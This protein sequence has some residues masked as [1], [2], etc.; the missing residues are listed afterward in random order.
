MSAGRPNSWYHECAGTLGQ[1][2]YIRMPFTQTAELARVS[3]QQLTGASQAATLTIYSR[4]ISGD[5]ATALLWQVDDA[6]GF[7]G[8]TG[9]LTEFSNLV[10]FQN[11]TPD[12]SRANPDP[13]IYLLIDVPGG[14]GAATWGVNISGYSGYM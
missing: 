5:T 6:I 3:I 4:D 1:K 9:Q 8:T 12:V 11:Q 13:S 7:T 2:N 10:P 14:S